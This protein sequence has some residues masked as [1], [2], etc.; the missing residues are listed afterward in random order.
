MSE[1]D[2]GSIKHPLLPLSFFIALLLML[3]PLPLDWRWARPELVALLTV[4]WTL[5]YP[6]KLG[7]GMA[8]LIGILQDLVVGSV[9]GQHALAL[10]LMVYIVQIS[11]QRLKTYGSA[12]QVL[13]LVLLL[14]VQQLVIHWVNAIV[15]HNTNFLLYYAPVLISAPLW[16]ILRSAIDSLRMRWRML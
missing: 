7:V 8:F 1:R 15:G 16:P 5:Y 12:L 9:L 13:W 10:V 4:Y 14:G 11:H 6:E 3:L 2:L